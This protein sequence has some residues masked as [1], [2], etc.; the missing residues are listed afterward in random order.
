MWH[1]TSTTLAKNRPKQLYYSTRNN[2]YL[3]ARHQVGWYPLSLWVNLF[4]VCPAKMILLGLFTIQNARGIW[5]GI[6]HWRQHR[7]GWADDG[8][9][10]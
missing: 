7:Y 10:R 2:L 4:A 3:T 6:R 5:L 9:F 1:K 8:W